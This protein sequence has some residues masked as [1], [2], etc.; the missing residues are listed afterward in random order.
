MVT[1]ADE[2]VK[3]FVDHK[4]EEAVDCYAYVAH[5]SKFGALNAAFMG[6][7]EYCRFDGHVTG[8]NISLNECSLNTFSSHGSSFLSKCHGNNTS[9]TIHGSGR[10][11]VSSCHDVAKISGDHLYVQNVKNVREID[12]CLSSTLR[13]V[14]CKQVTIRDKSKLKHCTIDTLIVHNP[15]LEIKDCE[16]TNLRL[17]GDHTRPKVL[18]VKGTN[19][20]YAYGDMEGWTID[21]E[22]GCVLYVENCRA[23]NPSCV[24]L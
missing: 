4:T 8:Y 12:A 7:A 18:Y 2:T 5:K 21:A 14:E 13:N 11:G 16:I 22:N 3:H 15:F 9:M 24:I 23:N 10:L 17:V 6:H 1:E 20:R 19:I